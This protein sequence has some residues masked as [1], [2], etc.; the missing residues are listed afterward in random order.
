VTSSARSTTSRNQLR[1]VG[2]I[3]KSLTDQ[4]RVE[5][6]QPMTLSTLEEDFA[7]LPLLG[8]GKATACREAMVS[9][10]YSDPSIHVSRGLVRGSD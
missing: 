4:D 10:N 9:D 5:T 3:D 6:V 2:S 7:H 1:L 8:E